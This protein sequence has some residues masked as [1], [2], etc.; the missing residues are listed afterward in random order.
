MSSFRDIHSKTIESYERVA[1]WWDSHRSKKLSEECWLRELTLA[2]PAKGKV[3]DAGCG[4]GSPIA[5]YFI[6]HGYKVTGV[7]G[8]AAMIE[9]ARGRF[10]QCRWVQMDMRKLALGEKFDAII[11]WDSFFH[12]NQA[13]QRAVLLLFREHL[14]AGGALLL[15]VGHAAGEVLGEVG[16]EP[17]YH[18]S[19]SEE[20]YRNILVEAGFKSVQFVAQDPRCDR[21]VL[22]ATELEASSLTLKKSITRDKLD[23]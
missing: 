7:D 1:A 5:E 4:G 17:V 3:L 21:T 8:A 13:E 12:L 9:L 22:M 18:S 11:G 14:R 20:E 19:L 2:I 15:S 10:P 16:G 6:R 23:T